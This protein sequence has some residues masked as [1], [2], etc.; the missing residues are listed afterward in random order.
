MESL[1]LLWTSGI[2]PSEILPSQLKIQ[3]SGTQTAA[4]LL[5]SEILDV[6]R[7]LTAGQHSMIIRLCRG[8]SQV[9]LSSSG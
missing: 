9:F 3:I 8:V 5:S 7:N 4:A 1:Y 6:V 2:Y